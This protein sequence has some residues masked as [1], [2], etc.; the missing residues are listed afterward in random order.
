VVSMKS[1]GRRTSPGNEYRGPE[2]EKSRGNQKQ[3]ESF[4]DGNAQT[5]RLAGK[6]VGK[7]EDWGKNTHGYRGESI[8]TAEEK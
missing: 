8:L 4:R 1:D 3:R 2:R 5:Q 6:A 7:E